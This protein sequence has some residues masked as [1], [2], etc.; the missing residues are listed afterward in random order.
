MDSKIHIIKL[1]F[2]IHHILFYQIILS[3]LTNN[4]I[5]NQNSLYIKTKMNPS[6]NKCKSISKMNAAINLQ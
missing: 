3:K 5:Y 4:D 1:K 6:R 2:Y